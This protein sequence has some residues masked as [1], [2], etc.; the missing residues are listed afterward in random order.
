MP[1]PAVGEHEVLLHVH[2]A[3]VQYSDLEAVSAINDPTDQFHLGKK[4]RS[5]QIVG[6][7]AAGEIVAVGAKVKSVKPGDKVT[8]LYFYDYVDGP[9]TAKRQTQ[10]RGDNVSGVFGDYVIVEENGVAPKIPGLS[11]EEAATLPTAA[12]TAWMATVGAVGGSLVHRGDTAVVEGTGGVSTFALQ[13]VVAAG[14]H[15]IVVSSSDDKLEKA[16]SLGAVAGVNYRKVPNWADRV[17]ELTDG[18]GAQ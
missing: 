14:A 11:Y 8:S 15:A 9:L 18:K 10:G 16:R 4:D 7:D 6:S 17:K 2:A 5:G 13:F 3:A 1:V 12:L